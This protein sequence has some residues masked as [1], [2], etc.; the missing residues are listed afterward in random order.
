MMFSVLCWRFL[1]FPHELCL[2]MPRI[3]NLRTLDLSK[4]SL[5]AVSGKFA[6][7][8][9]LTSI[10]LDKN[11]LTPGSL[12]P[13]ASLAK[14]QKLSIGDNLLGKP[15]AG[16]S[17]K[18]VLPELPKGL[19]QLKINA[20]FLSHI[21]RHIMSSHLTKLEKLDL[22][23]NQLALI[24]V[25]IAKLEQLTE[26]NLDDNVIVSIP[27]EAGL[28]KKLKVLSL[29]NNRISYPSSNNTQPLPASLFTETPLIDLN[30]HGNPMT[31]TQLNIMEGYDKF[32]KRRQEVK[33]SAL[34]GG[35]LTN[36]DVCGLE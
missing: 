29:R 33:T 1:D 35:A 24:P 25:D 15:T 19:K 34:M 20:N 14:L 18:D 31:S 27:Q 22:S 28:L 9:N 10:N 11:K 13:I 16:A 36:L 26:L 2:S 8:K 5:T 17:K 3:L 21:P 12:A 4:N 32:L 7:L 6:N 30:L 23:H